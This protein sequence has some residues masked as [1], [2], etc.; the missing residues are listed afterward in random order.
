[1]SVDIYFIC[2]EWKWHHKHVGILSY[3]GISTCGDIAP[4]IQ[5]VLE[6]YGLMSREASVVKD[7]G[8]NLA[9]TTP[10]SLRIMD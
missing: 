4:H 1:M 9:T 10:K 6:E 7:G 3:K 2:S 8:G 5:R